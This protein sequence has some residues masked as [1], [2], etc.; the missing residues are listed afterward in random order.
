MADFRKLPNL[1][2]LRAFEAAARHES[3][4]RAAEEIH[5]TPGAIS[6]QIRALEQELGLQLFTRNGKRIAGTDAGRRFAAAIRKSL[7]DIAAAA[8]TLQE[9]HGRQRLVVS[10]PPSFASR[11][12]APRLWKF[13]DRHPDIEVIL[14]SSSH[15]NDLARDG[16]DVGVR[17]G[18]GVYPGL[19]SEKVMEDFYYPVASPRYRQGRLPASPQELRD[20][21]LLRMDGLQESWLPWFELAGL[22]LP[23]PAGGLVTEDSSLTLR[24]AADG[25]GVALTRHAI[26][27]QEIAAGELVRLF[28]IALKSERGYHFVYVAETFNKPQIQYFRNWL[29]EEVALFQSNGRWPG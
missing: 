27:S 11:W 8:E 1:A 25:A 19:K 23:D 4:S 10:S 21:T 13:I 16:I 24:A 2:A 17:F 3:F 15:L 6:H 18:L 7:T 22:D 28:D 9:Q 26:A 29:L 20:C 12:L 5:V 14:Q